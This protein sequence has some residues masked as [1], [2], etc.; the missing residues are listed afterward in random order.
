MPGFDGTG[1]EGRGP[2]TGRGLGKCNPDNTNPNT[3]VAE[4][5]DFP[6]YGRGR[7]YGRG[8]GRGPAGRGRGRG[9]GF[10]RGGRW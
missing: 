2:R 9:F 10:G 7:G 6:P 4:N 3:D 8:N 1:P 5:D